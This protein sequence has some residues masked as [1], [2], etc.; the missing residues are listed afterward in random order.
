MYLSFELR[1]SGCWN[2]EGTAVTR[3]TVWALLSTLFSASLLCVTTTVDC[4]TMSFGLDLRYSRLLF[5]CMEC[6]LLDLLSDKWNVLLV[7]M[8]QFLGCW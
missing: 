7:L 8:S 2:E 1:S 5:Q 6:I 3:F 4:V